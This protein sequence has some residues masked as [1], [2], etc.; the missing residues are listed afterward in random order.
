MNYKLLKYIINSENL[1][2]KDI[3]SALSISKSAYYRKAS[4]ATEFTRKEISVMINKLDLSAKQVM[5]IF[6]TN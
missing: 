1:S 6:F 5:Q 4:G 3:I 2:N